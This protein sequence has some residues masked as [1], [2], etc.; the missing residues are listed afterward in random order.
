MADELERRVLG[1]SSRRLVS[2]LSALFLVITGVYYLLQRGRGLPPALLNNKVL[3][4]ALWYINV[5]L[6]LAILYVLVRSLFRLLLERRHRILGSKFKTKLVLSAIALSL[7]P[8]LIL[9]PFATRLVVDSFE[10]WLSL[11]IEQVVSEGDQVALALTGELEWRGLRDAGRVLR[12][13]GEID[14]RDLSQQAELQRRL[15]A[16]RGELGLHYLLVYDGTEFV[17]GTADP[18][19]G[20]GRLPDVRRFNRFLTE[21]IEQGERSRVVRELGID[22]HL[23]LSAQADQRSPADAEAGKEGRGEEAVAGDAAEDEA[24]VE[25]DSQ[26]PSSTVVV[27]G[28]LLGSELAGKSERLRAAHQAYQRLAIEKEAIR[29]AYLSILLMVTLLVILAFSAIGL[30]LARRVTEPIQLLADATRRIS[31]GDLDH[32]IE[33]AVDDELRVL[34]DDFNHMAS[35]LERN[36]QL[37][38]RANHRLL[39]AN[40]RLAA[41]LG[42][43]TAGVISLDAEGRISTCNGAALGILK[44]RE[45]EV[46]GQPAELAWADPE[47]T[48]LAALVARELDGATLGDELHLTIGGVWKTLDVKVKELPGGAQTGGRVVVLEDLTELIRAQKMATWTEVARRIAHEI[49]NPLTPIKL[50]AERLLRKHRSAADDFPQALETGVEVIAREVASMKG[51]VDEFS[52]YARMPRPQPRK[53]DLGELFD[54]ILRL[55][56][57]LKRGVAVESTIGAGAD[58]VLFDHEQLRGVLINLLDN[59]LEATEAPG[60]VTLSSVLGDY[61]LDKAVLEIAVA[62]TGRGIP[63]QDT[64]K[65]FQPYYSTKGRGTGLGL[66]IVHRVVEEHQA[67]I[68]V[69]DNRPRGTVFVL[70]VPMQ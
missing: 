56:R 18:E 48:K 60:K 9:F 11:P 46:I 23:V 8:V 61:A 28:T 16:L 62:D 51:M 26:E 15:R 6:I 47:R 58:T 37:V 22:G 52:S 45:D 38:D 49:K 29:G 70:E 55:Y 20:I 30:R 12:E 44:Q 41:V 32:R 40:E 21:T 10:L 68:R 17:Q 2:V 13:I 19:K 39:A 54:D 43:V 67:T 63:R 34:V 42:N 64:D 65:V 53:I 59:A 5:I 66:A 50:T 36:R 31:S 1:Q 14:L 25:D 4:F 69:E 35:E 24:A 27:V 7:V 3:L 57:G 33:V